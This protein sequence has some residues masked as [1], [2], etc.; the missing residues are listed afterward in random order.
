MLGFAMRA[1][2][3]TVGTES[4]IASLKKSGKAKARLV[5]ISSTASGATAKKVKSQC[6]FYEVE[7]IKV[8]ISS[9]DLGERLGKLY[10]PSAVG[11]TDDGFARELLLC[12]P[13]FEDCDQTSDDTNNRKEVSE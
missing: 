7:C 1:G 12:A 2:K 10:A 11:I 4:T 8:N 6:A 3:V 13:R 9:A 5:I